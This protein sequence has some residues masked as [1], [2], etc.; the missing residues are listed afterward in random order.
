M[1]TKNGRK[2]VRLPISGRRDGDAPAVRVVRAGYH[3]SRMG[4]WYRHQVKR[5]TPEGPDKKKLSR[6]GE[7][8]QRWGVWGKSGLQSCV[9]RNFYPTSLLDRQMSPT[10]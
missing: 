3:T 6:P 7:Y 5:S 1:E 8:F 4:E 9:H 10:A 2:W